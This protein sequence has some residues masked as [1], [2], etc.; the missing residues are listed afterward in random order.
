MIQQASGWTIAPF[1][2]ESFAM[3]ILFPLCYPQNCVCFRGQLKLRS[4]EVIVCNKLFFLPPAVPTYPAGAL[5]SWRNSFMIFLWNSTSTFFWREWMV[6][7]LSECVM[8]SMMF[9]AFRQHALYYQFHVNGRR[10]NQ[11]RSYTR[12]FKVLQVS[13]IVWVALIDHCFLIVS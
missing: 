1:M 9:A 12:V 4:Y 8:A 3:V 5:I 7:C 6:E 11:S 13:N 2:R 10:E